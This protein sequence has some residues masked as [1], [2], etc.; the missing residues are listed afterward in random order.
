MPSTLDPCCGRTLAAPRLHWRLLSALVLALAALD[1]A[2]G[3]AAAPVEVKVLA[4]ND[5][6]GSLRTPP[7]SLRLADAHDPARSVDVRAGGAEHLATR[8]QQLK[9]KNPHHVFVAA[10]DLVGASP[11]LS[12]LFRDEPTIEALSQMGLEFAAVGNHEFD[13]GAAELLRLQHGGCAEDGG[14]R[15][16][17]PF[18]GASFQYLAASTFARR[19]G[20]ALLPAYRV[21]RFAGVAVAFIGLTLRSTPSMVMRSGVR[22]LVFR[23][24]ARSVNALVPE[25]RRQGIEAIVLL[26]HQGGFPTGGANECPG[27]AGPVVDILKKLDRAVDVVIS[28]HTHRAYNCRIDGRL[29]TSAGSHGRL[30]TEIDLVLDPASGDVTAAS[31]RNHVV[32]AERTPKDARQTALIEAYE[33]LAQPLAQRVVAPLAAALP[34]EAN[35]AGESA[36][37]QVLADA[38]LEATR[39]AGAQIALVNPGG[40]RAALVPG[41]DGL[42]R[43]EQLFAVQPF[44]NRLVTMT[45]SGAQLAALLEQQW[46]GQPL[47]AGRV[48]HVSRGF[49]YTWDAARPPGQRVVAASLRLQGRRLAADARVRVTV[50]SFMAE[51]GDRFGVLRQ[52]RE[53]QA[54]PLDVEALEA[55]LKAAPA[56]AQPAQRR[57]KRLH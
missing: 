56:P 27:I 51:G 28:G 47:A 40:V 14:C 35:A 26:L 25:L 10:G 48:L 3:R 54:G 11:L 42:L 45:L 12:A 43:Y 16:P 1:G 23:D 52:G 4:I 21:K 36:I 41:P 17:Q 39:A 57:I 8:V 6:H 9:A 15:G 20:R 7:G 13:R 5:F 44:G 32:D 18:A 38:Q 24:E 2:A 46:R 49:T 30:L 53:R 50:N 29:L 22:G 34:R 33:R 19:S 37:G 55:Y 31:A